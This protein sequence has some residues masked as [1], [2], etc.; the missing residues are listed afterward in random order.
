M[1]DGW[2]GGE[3]EIGATPYEEM[4]SDGNFGRLKAVSR[5][6]TGRSGVE[7]GAD[8]VEEILN[9]ERSQTGVKLDSIN[10]ELA[11][12]DVTTDSVESFANTI[13]EL[14]VGSSSFKFFDSPEFA[15]ECF[16]S[17]GEVDGGIG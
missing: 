7:R 15:L 3:Q 16:H 12:E 14:A 2:A 4:G 5:V 9:L 10:V 13:L 17:T 6:P 11:A 1:I 8:E